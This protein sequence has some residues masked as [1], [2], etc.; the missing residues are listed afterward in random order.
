ML[1]LKSQ[2]PAGF[3][4]GLL[5]LVYST[6]VYRDSHPGLIKMRERAKSVVTRSCRPGEC[7][8]GHD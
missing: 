8:G 6:A 3:G 5:V 4:S 7:K 2:N 1:I